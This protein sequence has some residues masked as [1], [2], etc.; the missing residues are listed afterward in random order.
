MAIEA[1]APREVTVQAS[2]ARQVARAFWDRFWQWLIYA[3]AVLVVISVLLIF[4]FLLKESLP[5]F[6][7]VS[8][9]GLVSGRDWQPL[10][11]QFGALPLIGG[12]LITTAIAILIALPLGVMCAV[13]MGELAP[14]RLRTVLK[15]TVEMLAGVPSVVIGFIGVAILVPALREA[16]DLRTGQ[17]AFAG[18]LLLAFMALPTIISISEDALHAVPADYR[19]ASL[20]LGG[21]KMQTIWAAVV[22]AAGRGIVAAVM[23]GLGRAIGETM[24]VLMVTGNAAVVPDKLLDPDIANNSLFFSIRTLTATIA[25]EMGEVPRDS[26]HWHCLFALGLVLFLMTFTVNTA[27]DWALNRGK[28]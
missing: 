5:F 27:A 15:S 19:Q 28:R 12:T 16:L 14:G 18:G 11:E 13:Y 10:A 22:P 26:A 8:L 25:Q 24:T 1:T 7:H 20:A 21:T 9:W 6:Q 2:R 4:G 3:N 23:L 17:T